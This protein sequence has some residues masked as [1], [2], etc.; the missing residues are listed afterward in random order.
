MDA[1]L[2]EIAFLANSD[3]RVAILESLRESPRQRRDL[4]ASVDASRVTVARI[5]RELEERGWVERTGREY[6]ATPLGCWVCERFTELRRDFEA[7]C[8]LREPLQWLPSDVVTFDIRRLRDAEVR[9]ADGSDATALVR[10]LVSFH[11]SG[12]RIRAAARASAP[13]VVENLR[14]VVVDRGARLELVSTP[15]VVDAVRNHAPSARCARD[16]VDHP[17]ADWS[18]CETVPIAVCVVDDTVRINL[19]DEQGVLRGA[20]VTDDQVVHAWAV[21]VFETCRQEASPLDVDAVT[22]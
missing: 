6:A 2:D 4:V 8:R 14:E 5:L 10:E 16:L 12:D 22:A 18:I 7:G 11:R 21:D 9:L 15:A 1:A 19:T 13:R 17:N 3:N 20:L